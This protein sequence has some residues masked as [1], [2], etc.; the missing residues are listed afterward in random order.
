M[1]YVV[2]KGRDSSVPSSK[3]LFFVS[4]RAFDIAFSIGCAPIFLGLCLLIAIANPFWNPGPLF[5]KQLRRGKDG[6]AFTIYKFR[7]MSPAKSRTRGADE[8]LEVERVTPLGRLL[9]KSQMD[10]LPQIINVL[11]GQMSVV[12]PRPEIVEFAETY[13]SIIPD[14]SV[15][16]SVRPGITGYAQVTQGYTDSIEMVHRKTELDTH[17]V[18]NMNWQME[19]AILIRTVFVVYGFVKR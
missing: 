18:H 3:A 11:M 9:R 7:S 5:Y 16:E 13:A 19:I 12:G 2:D 15:R 6:N 17:Y 1:S 8:P 14:Y 10:E 4:K